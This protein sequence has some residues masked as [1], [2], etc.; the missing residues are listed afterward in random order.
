[1]AIDD[2]E[3]ATLSLLLDEIFPSKIKNTVVIVN[4]PH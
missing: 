2:N 4:N 3:L 1:V